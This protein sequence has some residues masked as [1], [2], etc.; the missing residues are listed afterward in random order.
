MIANTRRLFVRLL[1]SLRI[2]AVC[3]VGSMNG[4]EALAFR[5]ALPAADIYALEPNPHNLQRMQADARLAERDIRLLP[6]AASDSD[7]VAD[8]YLVEADAPD[9][10]RRGMSSLYP[11]SGSWASNAATRVP[12]TRLDTLLAAKCGP[13]LRLALWIDAEGKAYEVLAGAA[14]LARHI[15]LVHVE[16]ES[17]RCIAPQQRLYP[18]VRALLERLGLEEVA[19]DQPHSCTQFNAVFVRHAQP[20]RER[21]RLAAVLTGT[22]AR[23]LL[24]ASLARVCPACARR[25]QARNGRPT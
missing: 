7:G 23:G 17:E 18:E 24:F 4:A 3:D 15:Q 14:G 9:E 5:A 11:R 25:H 10:I 12:T 19:T 1:R 21:A 22:R 13:Q 20:A 2:S 6:L 8:F 16:V